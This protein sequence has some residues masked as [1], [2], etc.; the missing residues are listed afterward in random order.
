MKQGNKAS[1]GPVLAAAS[2]C[3]AVRFPL[4][5]Q[6]SAAHLPLQP[7]TREA[8]QPPQQLALAD[9]SL[10]TGDF[11]AESKLGDLQVHLMWAGLL[12]FT[13]P[14]GGGRGGA[15]AARLDPA[16]P[17]TYHVQAHNISLLLIVTCPWW[18]FLGEQELWRRTSP[19]VLEMIPSGAQKWVLWQGSAGTHAVKPAW[20]FHNV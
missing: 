18:H 7:G 3:Y 12:I 1:A 20:N 10:N 14:R 2:Q 6:T 4:T 9:V 8:T 17:R 15:I 11:S 13:S 5:R 19:T 16:W